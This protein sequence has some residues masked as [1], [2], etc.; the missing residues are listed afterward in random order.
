MQLNITQPLTHKSQEVWG[1]LKHAIGGVTLKS[2]LKVFFLSFLS[3]EPS[4]DKSDQ[5][6]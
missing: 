5:P 2:T 1:V 3:L 4:E 6:G